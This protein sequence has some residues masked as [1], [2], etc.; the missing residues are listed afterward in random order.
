MRDT[1]ALALWMDRHKMR[2]R[3]LPVGS[4]F[5]LLRTGERFTLVRKDII[6][7]AGVRYVVVRDGDPRER[8]LHHAC[9][10]APVHQPVHG[11][12]E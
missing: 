6:T 11:G 3:K 4:A 12:G 7:P 9:Y 8:S 2:L 5:I 1:P 10:V